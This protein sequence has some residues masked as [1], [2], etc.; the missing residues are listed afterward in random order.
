MVSW[1]NSRCGRE[2]WL[3]GFRRSE[4]L[5]L[6]KSAG[7]SC[8]ALHGYAWING[9]CMNLCILHGWTC[10]CRTNMDYVVDGYAWI[11]GLCMNLCL[12]IICECGHMWCGC[13]CVIWTYCIMWISMIFC[14]L[15][16]AGFVKVSGSTKLVA[17]TGQRN[18][19]PS[20]QVN[21]SVGPRNQ[22]IFL[23]AHEFNSA[24]LSVFVLGNIF[25]GRPTKKT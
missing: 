21:S 14:D 13:G 18:Y 16:G 17:S 24:I 2:W 11:N 20:A 12:C 1:P 6:S 8:V 5:Q 9:L 10:F 19:R 15:N 3:S 23:E 22:G 25:V 4:Q 7:A